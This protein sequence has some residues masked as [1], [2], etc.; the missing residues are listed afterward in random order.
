M[1]VGLSWAFAISTDASVGV[2]GIDTVR[3]VTGADPNLYNDNDHMFKLQH[4]SV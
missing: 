3:D 2:D 4:S 1:I